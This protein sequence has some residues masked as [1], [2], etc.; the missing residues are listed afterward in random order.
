MIL[1][2]SFAY[3]LI[4]KNKLR[5]KIPRQTIAKIFIIPELVGIELNSILNN[6]FVNI[7]LTV[8]LERY[9]GA[10]TYTDNGQILLG[11]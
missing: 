11:K 10:T 7:S 2:D 8:S 9:K 6:G 1:R 5:K 3:Y 4:A